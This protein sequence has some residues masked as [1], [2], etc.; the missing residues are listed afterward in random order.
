MFKRAVPVVNRAGMGI[1]AIKGNHRSGKANS[2]IV[3]VAGQIKAFSVVRRIDG[4][5]LPHLR[6]PI[7]NAAIDPSEDL[8]RVW[9]LKLDPL[10]LQKWTNA[11]QYSTRC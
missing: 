5:T 1:P 9:A 3:K 2:E 8:E 4:E 6:I 11:F 7:I 10:A